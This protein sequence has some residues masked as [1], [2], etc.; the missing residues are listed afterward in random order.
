MVHRPFLHSCS[1]LQ[2]LC[3]NC[4]AAEFNKACC[5]W[6]QSMQRMQTKLIIWLCVNLFLGQVLYYL[7]KIVIIIK[8]VCVCVYLWIL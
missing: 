8:N 2:R 4:E 1:V 6:A 3:A 5:V 7:E